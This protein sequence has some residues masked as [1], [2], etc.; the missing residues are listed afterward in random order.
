[1]AQGP[2]WILLL[3]GTVVIILVVAS[4]SR[5]IALDKI[6]FGINADEG[7]RAAT[8]IQIVRGNDTA[9]IFDSGWY[10]ISNFYFWLVAQLMKMIGIGYVQARVFGALASI[11]SVATITWL[12]IRHFNFA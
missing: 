11:I 12:G 5:L 10:F 1:M 2:Q 8:S 9:S 7:D 3:L 4:A 6:P